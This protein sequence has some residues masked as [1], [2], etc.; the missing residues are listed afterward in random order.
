VLEPGASTTRVLGAMRR[1][2]QRGVRVECSLAGA[3]PRPL[4]ILS[5]FCHHN[6]P[7]CPTESAYVELEVLECKPLFAGLLRDIQLHAVVRGHRHAGL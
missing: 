3:S 1:A 6:H 5:R 2:A 7:A 4:L